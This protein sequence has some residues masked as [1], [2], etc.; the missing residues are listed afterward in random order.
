MNF[1]IFAKQGPFCMNSPWR[2]AGEHSWRKEG[3]GLMNFAT[4]GFCSPGELFR[5]GPVF[6]HGGLVIRR[7]EIV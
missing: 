2:I 6:C 3:S 4:L 5:S 7:S 1:M